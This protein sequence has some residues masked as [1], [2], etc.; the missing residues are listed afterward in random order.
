MKISLP[1]PWETTPEE[2]FAQTRIAL[3]ALEK[4][5]EEMSK[6][7][8]EEEINATI[9]LSFRPDPALAESIGYSLPDPIDSV[10]IYQDISLE[11][12]RA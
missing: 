7:L 6:G 8:T 5:Y 12:S 2:F 1:N 3:K 11:I 9:N 10:M 4:T